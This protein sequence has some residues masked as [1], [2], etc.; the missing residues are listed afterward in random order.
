M[1]CLIRFLS[2]SHSG[3]LETRDRVFD[4]DAL[5][6][7]RA[8][9]QVLHLKDRRVALAHARLRRRDRQLVIEALTTAGVLVN[10]AAIRESRLAPG[11]VLQVGANVLR[12][13]DPPADGPEVDFAFTFE[14]DRAARAEEAVPPPMPRRL[15]DTGLGMRG[16]SW[17]LFVAVLAG[18]L[19]IPASGLYDG[20]WQQRLRESPLPDD[21]LWLSGPL[22]DVHQVVNARCEACHQQPFVQVRDAACLDCHAVTLRQ[23]A[24]DF[25]GLLAAVARGSCTG[26]HRE[27]DG[28][29][30]LVRSDDALCADCHRDIRA[31]AGAERAHRPASD[32]L[33]EHP[34]FRVTTLSLQPAP[35]TAGPHPGWRRE[36]R[37]ELPG[38]NFA[39][40]SGLKFPHDVHLRVDGIEAPLGN[41]VLACADCHQPEP[42]GARFAPV[43]MQAHCRD[44]HRLDFDPAFPERQVPHGPASGVLTHLLEYYAKR[45]LEEFA[46]PLNIARPAAGQRRPGAP[47]TAAQ[48]AAAL[49]RARA[50]SVAV[51]RDL[52]ER[53][54][55]VHCH[56]VSVNEDAP[57]ERRWEVRPVLLTTAWMPAA[58]FSHQSHGTSLTPCTTCHLAADSGS[59]TDILMPALADC[60]ACHAGSSPPRG[61]MNL[62]ASG[63]ATCHSFHQDSAPP[64]H[65]GGGLAR[66]PAGGWPQGHAG[67]RAR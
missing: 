42:G 59:A 62:L 8:T 18:A 21:R 20:D 43:S 53:R 36:A 17:L 48:R 40:A 41:V 14:L 15:A 51:A 22:A 47:L 66:W 34:E 19:V 52:I 3:A 58:S 63:C 26:C 39:E 57:L 23:H 27:H 56:E 24:E 12:I 64:W 10:G 65:G 31:V 5:T 1:R 61:A 60:R 38:G 25:D 7:G 4:G 33:R 30:W 35:G 11:D 55:C 44:C 46:D 49:E 32:F 45:Y 16:W 50:E 2:R 9:D 13:I 28:S 54:S 67:L 29:A 37:R 6:L